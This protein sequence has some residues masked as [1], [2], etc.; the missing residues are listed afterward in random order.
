MT[1]PKPESDRF[2]TPGELAR[3]W[4]CARS[5]VD[6]IARRA[7]FKR[8]CPGHGARG[9]VRYLREEVERYEQTRLV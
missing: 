6:R 1:R 9:M 4:C 7:G 8:F 2:I 5:T 3:R